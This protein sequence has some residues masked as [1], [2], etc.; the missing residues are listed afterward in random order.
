MYDFPNWENASLGNAGFQLSFG[1]KA[2]SAAQPSWNLGVTKNGQAGESNDAQ[3]AFLRNSSCLLSKCALHLLPDLGKSRKLLARSCRRGC[4]NC[5]NYTFRGGGI[6]SWSPKN[7][8]VALS[9]QESAVALENLGSQHLSNGLSFAQRLENT[10]WVSLVEECVELF[11]ELDR[12][13]PSLDPPARE[14]AD[15]L[16]FRLREILVRS[17]ATL[18]S[19]DQTF[20]RNRHRPEPVSEDFQPG[21]TIVE[22]MS[23]GFAIDR[24]VLR[25]ARVKVT[26]PASTEKGPGS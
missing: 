26:Q 18:I 23:P 16:T 12:V 17:G 6:S 13:S 14:F 25:R 22:T 8:V 21:A 24:R 20:D 1:L 9:H 19:E 15:H 7:E 11:D 10:A 5:D 3:A 2:G 4:N